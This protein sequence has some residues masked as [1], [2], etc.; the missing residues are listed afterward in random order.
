[1]KAGWKQGLVAA[2]A[3]VV[4]AGCA[5]EGP[6][7]VA[8]DADGG[9]IEV[10]LTRSDDAPTI[11]RHI[12]G[13]FAEHLGRGIYDGFLLKDGDGDWR[14][15]D[16]VIEALKAIR[17]PNLRWPGGCFADYYHWRD[18]VGPKDERPTIVNA[19][20]GGV[21]EDNSFGAHEFMALV[22]RLDTEPFVVGNVGSG[23]VAEMAAW[24]E[25]MNFPGE[26]PMADLRRANGR[27]APW[28][29]A[30]WGVGN[31]SWGC[32]GHMTPEYYANEYKRYATFLHQYG[33]VKPYRVAAGAAGDDY[34]WTEV[35]MREAGNR[36]EAL[37]L[38]HYTLAGNWTVKGDAVE[39]D[40]SGWFSAIRSAWDVETLIDG[41]AAIMDRY[42]P[43]KRV[44][45]MVGEWGMWHDPAPGTNPGF[46]E[47]QNTLRDALVAALQLNI[48]NNRADRVRAANIAQ[49]VNVLQAMVLTRGAD[50][51][52]TPTY[53]VFEM[54]VPHHDATLLKAKVSPSRY[55]HD[56]TAVPAVSVSASAREGG[57]AFVTL[58]NVDPNAGRT[59][60]VRLEGARLTRVS[61]RVLTA[62]AMNAHNTFEAKGAVAPA[63]FD[64]AA[65]EDGILVVTLPPM[66][67]AAL[68][69]E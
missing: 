69:A 25:Y 24:W 1:M 64:G 46:L 14:M 15:R 63:A 39:F 40:E 31:E 35:L 3:L 38:H 33:G 8:S 13:H 68:A 9:A 47:Q 50:M 49:T 22:E 42:D 18:G 2:A 62:E 11:S 41:H 61:G 65:I 44:A 27:D 66:A 43:E 55:S 10:T 58:V 17:V 32:G 34:R 26:S 5:G 12:Y 59:L 60:R 67:L 53:H 28:N 19:L 20:W 51:L 7:G 6:A 52:L 29:V 4:A 36:M 56:G 16:D 21:T 45:L 48:Y 23:T 57:G 54:Y 30:M 37:D